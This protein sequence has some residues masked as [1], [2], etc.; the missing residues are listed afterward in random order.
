MIRLEEDLGPTAKE[1]SQW[2]RMAVT[3][4]N[5]LTEARIKD[6]IKEKGELSLYHACEEGTIPQIRAN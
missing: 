5:E 4:G 6:L 2:M 1:T 3:A